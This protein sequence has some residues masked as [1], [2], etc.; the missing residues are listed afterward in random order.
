MMQI[1]NV[2]SL[3][4]DQRRRCEGAETDLIGLNKRL[5]ELTH[6][7]EAEKRHIQYQAEERLHAESN[8]RMS[9][10]N[11]IKAAKEAEINELNEEAQRSKVSVCVN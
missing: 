10:V 2:Q 9:E 8:S 3:Y 4:Q 11:E 5:Q 1:G 6:S 7:S